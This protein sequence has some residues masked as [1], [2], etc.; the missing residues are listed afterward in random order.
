MLYMPINI[1]TPKQ[2]KRHIKIEELTINKVNKNKR[3]KV[4][5]MPEIGN[6]KL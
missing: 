6:P 3:T 1:L 2:W 4:D 5:P